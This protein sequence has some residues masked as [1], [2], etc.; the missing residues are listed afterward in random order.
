MFNSMHKHFITINKCVIMSN[1]HP[2]N[3]HKLLTPTN[4]HMRYQ[5]STRYSINII[6]TILGHHP[7]AS[8]TS[9][10]LGLIP[11]G[12]PTCLQGLKPRGR[13]N[14]IHPHRSV[15]LEGFRD[16]HQRTHI[17]NISIDNAYIT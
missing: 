9:C 2:F 13:T 3:N 7:R 8:H 14:P 11:K 1:I 15:F 12:M 5:C 17:N 4:L 10:L 16:F 6:M